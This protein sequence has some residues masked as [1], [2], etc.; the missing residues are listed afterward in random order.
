MVF[1]TVLGP[2]SFDAKGDRT[3]PDYDIFV[4]RKGRNGR[5]S[6]ENAGRS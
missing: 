2:L 1:K 6:Y 4:W 5:M 3:A